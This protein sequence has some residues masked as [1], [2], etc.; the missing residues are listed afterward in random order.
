[1][2][3]DV[4][5]ARDWWGT[6]PEDGSVSGVPCG[7]PEGFP[8]RDDVAGGLDHAEIPVDIG[9]SAES[10]GTGVV[11]VH[12]SAG[13][14]AAL[15]GA[16]AYRSRSGTPPSE[17]DDLPLSADEREEALADLAAG[18]ARPKIPGKNGASREV[19]R[20]CRHVAQVE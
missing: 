19:N 20:I 1:M 11:D 6:V 13:C 10:S 9:Y 3:T 7:G 14:R 18:C 8:S 12:G 17:P 16:D 15:T 5:G 2:D 4:L